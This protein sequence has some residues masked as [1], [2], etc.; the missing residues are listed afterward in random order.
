[1][2]LG[3]VKKIK[4]EKASQSKSSS[5][6]KPA[7][8]AMETNIDICMQIGSKSQYDNVRVN[9][10]NFGAFIVRIF[11]HK[12]RRS[13]NLGEVKVETINKTLVQT[14]MLCKKRGSFFFRR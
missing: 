2:T 11:E 13:R 8:G 12:S 10:A 4:R 7:V 5:P 1:V 9:C 3:V 14:E 6:H